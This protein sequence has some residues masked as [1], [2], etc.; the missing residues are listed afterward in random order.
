MIRAAGRSPRPSAS[1]VPAQ[2]GRDIVLTLDRG[3]QYQVEQQLTAEVASV[4]AK[5]GMALI[6]DVHS[7]DIL[8]AAVVDGA[9]GRGPA[10]PAAP[11]EANRLFTTP[12]EPGSTNKVIT[13]ASALES[14]A[15]TPETRFDV[16]A[17]IKVGG[18][19][20]DDDEWHPESSWSIR[21]ILPESSNV[22]TIKVAA[23]IGQSRLERSL[24]EFGLGVRTAVGFPGESGGTL[25]APDQGD[26]TIMGSL[27]IGY[28]VNATA[29]Q[30]LGVYMTIANGG[31]TRPL[32]LVDGTIDAAGVRHRSGTQP[33]RRVIS[34][35]TASILNELMRG[36]VT[37]GTGEQ[38][39]IPGYTVA[40]KTGTARKQPYAEHRYMASFAGFAPAEA[41]RYAAV[42]V[43]DEPKTQIYGGAVAAPVFSQI[44]QATLRQERVAPTV[45]L[46]TG[47]QAPG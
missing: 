30:T 38:A 3:L 42:V 8:A 47:A 4:K 5:G 41:P 46:D 45:A 26:P 28:G 35:G 39:A 43:L 12:Y 31:V 27:P 21:E 15:I 2:A 23:K 16:P 40:G 44:M 9:D 14:H 24:R 13:I 25:Q 32:R 36:V 7:G 11:T 17:R 19:N 1:S 34:S 10:R 6:A 18:A 20:F 29:A 22:G 37:H 33:S